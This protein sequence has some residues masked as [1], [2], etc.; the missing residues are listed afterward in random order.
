MNR[1]RINLYQRPAR[2]LDMLSPVGLACL[3][4]GL[5]VI[6]GLASAG[7]AWKASHNEQAAREL[8]ASVQQLESEAVRLRSRLASSSADQMLVSAIDQREQQL[9]NGERL[10]AGLG[11]RLSDTSL[12]FSSVLASLAREPLDGVWL[13][14]IV[15]GSEGGLLFEGRAV[16]ADRIP[17]FVERLGR[18]PELIGREFRT[19]RIERNGANERSISFSLVGMG[20]IDARDN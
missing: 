20:V 6:L 4:C 5:L 3:L 7:L 10:L 16:N 19:L 1:Q 14:R 11:E 9:A 13:R 12:G 15:I 18:E 17:R 8:A 2:R